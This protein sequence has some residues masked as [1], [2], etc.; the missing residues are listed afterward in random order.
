MFASRLTAKQQVLILMIW[1][2]GAV[3]NILIKDKTNNFLSSCK[4]EKGFNCVN[5]EILSYGV[6]SV[7]KDVDCDFIFKSILSKFM[8][9]FC[10]F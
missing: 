5:F 9:V 3:F 10:K 8:A 4:T 6:T 7:L 2:F 1:T